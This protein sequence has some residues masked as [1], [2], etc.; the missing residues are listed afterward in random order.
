MSVLVKQIASYIVQSAQY[1]N[2]Y[3]YKR[4][5]EKLKVCSD[6]EFHVSKV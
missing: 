3:L 4:A 5:K 6:S 1:W 2:I